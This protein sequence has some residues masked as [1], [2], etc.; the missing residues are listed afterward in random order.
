MKNNPGRGIAPLVY[1]MPACVAAIIALKL[2]T[3]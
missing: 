3:G 1:V 2:I